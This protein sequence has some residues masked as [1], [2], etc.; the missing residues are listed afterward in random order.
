MNILIVCSTEL[1]RYEE[2]IIH[3]VAS[4]TGCTLEFRIL[5]NPR[6]EPRHHHLIRTV[7]RRFARIRQN[8]FDI[9]PAEEFFSYQPA[10]YAMASAEG[11]TY[12]IVILLGTEQV[13]PDINYLKA[14]RSEINMGLWMQETQ[15]RRKFTSISLLAADMATDWHV[16]KRISIQ[17][18][19]GV[20]NTQ[21]KALFH[22]RYLF[23]AYFFNTS[24]SSHYRPEKH[25]TRQSLVTYYAALSG[26]IVS[27]RLRQKKRNWKVALIDGEVVK[28]LNQPAGTF[29][30]DPFCILY[31]GER[32]IFFEELDNNRKGKISACRVEGTDVMEKIAVLEQPYHLSF[33]NIF[34]LNN[35]LLMV[36]EQSE[37]GR[38]DLY[39]AEQPGGKW[40]YHSTMIDGIRALDPVWTHHNG[41]YWLFVNKIEDFEHDNNERL[42]IYYT[43]DFFSGMWQPHKQNPVIINISK[44]RNAGNI[45]EKD[46]QLYR[47]AQNCEISYGA[48]VV[49]NKITLLT[50]DHYEEV[51]AGSL[52]HFNKSF[53]MHTYNTCG[54]FCVTD[55]LVEE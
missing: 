23:N 5:E 44:A 26:I 22:L 33:P 35:Q 54:D 52:N 25:A 50:E 28:M 19:K 42:Y 53:G 2:N 55:F 31:N 9:T 4:C 40:T 16:V 37:A 32:W 20:F 10:Q 1:Y 12:D 6:T 38:M 24:Y 17:S 11:K 46:G 30:A 3:Q 36:P 41:K 47:P 51:E 27:R 21:K 43:D 34:T 29:W 18:E 8:P 14:L 45:F 13:P 49:L 39:T 15:Q 7:D 48:E